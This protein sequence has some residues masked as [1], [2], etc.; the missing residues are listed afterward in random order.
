[1]YLFIYSFII[2]DIILTAFRIILSTWL[3]KLLLGPR[4][5]QPSTYTNVATYPLGKY[6]Q[7]HRQHSEKCVCTGG[8]IHM[9]TYT[10][11]GV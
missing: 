2:N 10:G 1:M 11:K 7:C 9:R 8:M 5:I 4:H 6:K 3:Y